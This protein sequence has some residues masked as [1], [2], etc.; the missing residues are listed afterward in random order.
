MRVDKLN[1]MTA[2]VSIVERGTLTAAAEDLDTSLPTIVRMLAGLE[3]SLGVRLL[4][5]T[6]RRIHLTDEGEHYLEHCR[7]ILREIRD[8]ESRLTS[9]G[10]AP[11]GRLSVTASVLFGRR[12]VAPIVAK[13]IAQHPAVKA[14][15][16]LVDRITSLVEEGIDVAVRIG[17][18]NDSS[19]VAVNVGS[20]RRV[21]CASPIYLKQRGV[22]TAYRNFATLRV[23][24]HRRQT[25]RLDTYRAGFYMQRNR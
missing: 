24:I 9:H 13:F 19:L 25:R 22:H 18:L 17:H 20:V 23:A 14:N 12:H 21:V 16:L 10:S 8:V 3:R 5:R 6:T 2:F 7:R 4:N 15:L 11:T 1:A